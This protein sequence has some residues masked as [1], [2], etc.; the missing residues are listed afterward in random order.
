MW[1]LLFPKV[2]ISLH[3]SVSLRESLRLSWESLINACVTRSHAADVQN[4]STQN[5]WHN[6]MGPVSFS[7][8]LTYFSKH[9][10]E[11]D[12]VWSRT[13]SSTWYVVLVSFAGDVLTGLLRNCLLKNRVIQPTMLAFSWYQLKMQLHYVVGEFG[14]RSFIDTSWSSRGNPN[15][16]G[17]RNLTASIVVKT[18]PIDTRDPTTST[19]RSTARVLEVYMRSSISGLWKG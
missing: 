19:T 15:T 10:A 12:M 6:L 7:R 8:W 2:R 18:S 14:T 1:L 5:L 3:V 13:V 11:I 16:K 17:K 4:R 9:I